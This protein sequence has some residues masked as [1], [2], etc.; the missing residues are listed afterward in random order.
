MG[1]GGRDLFSL[2]RG[3]RGVPF[4]S[5]QGRLAQEWSGPRLASK[6]RFAPPCGY[7]PS[8]DDVHGEDTPR[9]L[10]K[11][12]QPVRRTQVSFVAG[13]LRVV[14]ELLLVS[15][16]LFLLLLVIFDLEV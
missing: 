10:L 15:C 4:E 7:P 8:I 16:S 6:A 5:Y 3:E 13:Y 12:N 14:S 11:V 9:A 2:Q 1:S